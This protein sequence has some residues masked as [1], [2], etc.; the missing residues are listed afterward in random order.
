MRINFLFLLD[1]DGIIVDASERFKLAQ[2]SGAMNWD[3]AFDPQNV[4]LD[5]PM[6]DAL[7]AMKRIREGGSQVV[8]LTSRLE[9]MRQATEEWLK[10]YGFS[11]PR[12]LMKEE[13]NKFIKTMHWKW[14]MAQKM[15]DEFNVPI[16][17]IDDEEN[18]RESVGELEDVKCFASF[19]EFFK[20]NEI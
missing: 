4:P 11:G 13:K 18:N 19:E 1:L 9:H 2:A 10:E 3:I 16:F 20:E 5:R 15:K 8:F 6:P 12:L 17:F 7:E 14:R